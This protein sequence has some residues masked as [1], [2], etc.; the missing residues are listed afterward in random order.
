MGDLRILFQGLP[1]QKVNFTLLIFHFLPLAM[2]NISLFES[3]SKI[4]RTDIIKSVM[5]LR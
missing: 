5:S 4:I 2:T 3:D 1:I